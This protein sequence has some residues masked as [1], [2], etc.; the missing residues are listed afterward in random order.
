MIRYIWIF[1][2]ASLPLFANSNS[3]IIKVEGKSAVPNQIAKS[4]LDSK[5]L[6]EF[7]QRS[8]VS[9]SAKQSVNELENFYIVES[10]NL[11]ELK[12]NLESSDISYKI[13]ENVIFKIEQTGVSIDGQWALSQVNAP[14][15]WKYATGKGIVIGVVDTG[16]DY[17]HK[18]LRNSIWINSKEDL[19]GNGK[20]DAWS[21]EE[22]IDGVYGDL[23]GKDEDGNGYI[24]DVIGY[25]FVDQSVAN[26]LK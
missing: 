5:T 26:E 2:I 13:Y 10:E 16:L 24:D 20:F 21:S 14:E 23:N 11:S 6:K 18:N 12:S 1:L 4:F 17:L 8:D 7:K 3:Y 22:E 9:L 19:N 15:A 25:D